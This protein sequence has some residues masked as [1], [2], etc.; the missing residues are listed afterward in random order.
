MPRIPRRSFGIAIAVLFSIV[1]GCSASGPVAAPAITHASSASLPPKADPTPSNS[2]SSSSTSPATPAVGSL[3]AKVPTE[4]GD[5]TVDRL[6]LC[7]S[8]LITADP[9][10]LSPSSHG[11]QYDSVLV[12]CRPQIIRVDNT[13]RSVARLKTKDRSGDLSRGELLVGVATDS[14]IRDLESFYAA[15]TTEP[16]LLGVSSSFVETRR[17]LTRLGQPDT[18]ALVFPYSHYAEGFYYVGGS[19]FVYAATINADPDSS[20]DSPAEAV[21]ARIIAALRAGG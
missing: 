18:H 16:R 17:I 12:E 14:R 10:V 19:A 15:A 1:A 8:D 21:V 11:R 4:H 7:L 20:T 6:N 13:Y 5:V 3:Q 9:L 2:E